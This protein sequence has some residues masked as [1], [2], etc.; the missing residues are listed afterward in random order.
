MLV[1]L[2]FYVVKTTTSMLL[3]SKILT[4]CKLLV[5]YPFKILAGF[6]VPYKTKGAYCV[7]LLWFY[8][9]KPQAR[10]TIEDFKSA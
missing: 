7:S 6:G 9:V 2:F 8:V 3:K 10:D 5:S 4:A 1:L